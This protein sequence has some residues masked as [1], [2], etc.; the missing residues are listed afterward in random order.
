MRNK[1]KILRMPA[2][3]VDSIIIYFF[4][5]TRNVNIL[6]GWMEKL[7]VVAVGAL[8]PRGVEALEEVVLVQAVRAVVEV[9]V[10]KGLED[11]CRPLLVMMPMEVRGW[12]ALYVRG[13]KEL[14]IMLDNAQVR[15]NNDSR[16]MLKW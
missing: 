6:N 10:G 12:Q 2:T 9:T 3:L 15:P 11:D 13:A 8:I 16:M 1:C 14:V 7:Q 5:G 4:S